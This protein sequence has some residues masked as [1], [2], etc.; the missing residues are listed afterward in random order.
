MWSEASVLRHTFK[1]DSHIS[2]YIYIY[3]HI[4]IYRIPL[5]NIYMYLKIIL[6]IYICKQIIQ[7]SNILCAKKALKIPRT[8]QESA[9]KC[10]VRKLNNHKPIC[11]PLLT[12]PP[13]PKTFQISHFCQSNAFVQF[14]ANTLPNHHDTWVLILS[15]NLIH[16]YSSR[17]KNLPTIPCLP[18]KCLR[19][20]NGQH[21]AKSS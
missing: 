14:M 16:L 7:Q 19:P 17:S 9:A 12:T 13:D 10:Y 2:T 18:I 8:K 1:V 4:Y 3:M 20:S 6:Y 21:L 5:S 15:N 11:I